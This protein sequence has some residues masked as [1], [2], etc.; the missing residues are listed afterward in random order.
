MINSELDHVTTLEEFNSEIH[1]QQT[2]AHGKDYC[3]I[4]DVIRKYMADCKSYMELGVHQGGTASVGMLCNPRRV[5]LVDIDLS[6]YKKF[7]EPIAEKYCDDNDIEL[8]VNQTDSTGFG[9]VNMTDM[10]VIDSYHHPRHMSKELLIH[11]RNVKKYIIA[12]D[13]SNIGGKPDDR[14][15]QCLKTWSDQNGFVEVE[16]GTTNVGYVVFKRK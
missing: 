2:E 7:L 8:I 9:A 4:H 15:Y 13:T 14:L 10:L 5:Y 16:R 3:A 6:K 12:H 1:R 11:G